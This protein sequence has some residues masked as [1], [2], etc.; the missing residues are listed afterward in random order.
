VDSGQTYNKGGAQQSQ[1]RS[2]A[3][4]LSPPRP[5][6]GAA[7]AYPPFPGAPAR[8]AP[9]RYGQQSPYGTSVSFR[10]NP[11]RVPQVST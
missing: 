3:S 8:G 7:A 4:P 6:P 1:S 5:G 9:L 2:A 11:Y 10:D